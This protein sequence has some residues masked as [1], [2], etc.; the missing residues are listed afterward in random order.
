MRESIVISR[1]RA[2]TLV[3]R[4]LNR[5]INFAYSYDSEQDS[6]SNSWTKQVTKTPNIN[7]LPLDSDKPLEYR[8]GDTT[9]LTE[10]SKKLNNFRE[11]YVNKAEIRDK[12]KQQFNNPN[13]NRIKNPVLPIS[14]K[15]KLD[16]SKLHLDDTEESPLI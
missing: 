11:K 14:F 6:G 15:N 5:N 9:K 16:K 4:R 8:D 3:N 7:A 1:H 13:R 2:R 10:A 12:G